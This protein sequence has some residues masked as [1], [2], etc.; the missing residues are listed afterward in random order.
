[1][2]ICMQINDCIDCASCASCTITIKLTRLN[3][4]LAMRSNGVPA[5]LG[6]QLVNTS[7][8]FIT[9]FGHTIGVLKGL[10]KNNTFN[11]N[12]TLTRNV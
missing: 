5:L 10:R 11:V 6:K 2:R 4:N 1:M 12:Y 3:I 9:S 8:P 7:N